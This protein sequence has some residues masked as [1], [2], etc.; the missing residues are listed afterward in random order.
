MRLWCPKSECH[1]EFKGKRTKLQSLH[2][3]Y[4]CECG[5]LLQWDWQLVPSS[6]MY[7]PPKE[8]ECYDDLKNCNA[9]FP[10]CNPPIIPT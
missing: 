7:G 8:C 4:E 6:M 3:D 1:R 5:Q 2:E 9:K 10:L